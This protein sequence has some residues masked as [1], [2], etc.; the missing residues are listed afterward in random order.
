MGIVE[1]KTFKS[2]NSIAVRLP[3]DVAFA[4]D[5]AVTIERNGDVLTIR[6]VEDLAKEKRELMA[7]VAELDA[8]GPIG[9]VEQREPIE[10]SDRA[11]R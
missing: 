7:L 2:G 1:S 8:I 3:R 10:F 11:E 5:I 9:E 6:P 4:A